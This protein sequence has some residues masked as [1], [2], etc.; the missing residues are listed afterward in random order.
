M[1]D[2]NIHALGA[3]ARAGKWPFA[4]RL[5]SLPAGWAARA[6]WAFLG[7][8]LVLALSLRLFAIGDRPFWVDE[9]A[10]LGISRLSLAEFSRL[11][12]PVEANPP[13]YYLLMK[14]WYDLGG[15][16]EAWMRLPSALAGTATLVPFYFFCRR[17]FGLPAA[18][19]GIVLLA[20]T[21]QHVRFS[22]EARNYALFCLV[23]VCGLLVMQSLV[24]DPAPAGLR[25]WLLGGAL[26]ALSACL[27][28]LHATGVIAA[29]AI[30][31]Y[32]AVTL[33]ASGRASVRRFALLAATG[34]AGL[35]L[36][37]PW[38]VIAA[39]VAFSPASV[40]QW[41]PPL[42]FEVALWRVHQ[43]LF[44]WNLHS[45]FWPAVLATLGGL[46]GAVAARR[47][48]PQLWGLLAALGFSAACFPL[49]SAVV[50]PIVFERTLLFVALLMTILLASFV[51]APR[52]SVALRCVV[53]AVLLVSQARA[54]EL[55]YRRNHY[56]ELWDDAI[57]RLVR[58][59]KNDA[60]LAL[61]V[62]DSVVIEDTLRREGHDRGVAVLAL[63][64]EG[65]Y[66]PLVRA[67]VAPTAAWLEV[68]PSFACSPVAAAP[69][70]WIIGR[71]VPFNEAEE[72]R[73][74]PAVLERD[75]A[76]RRESLTIGKLR[77]EHWTSPGCHEG[78][79]GQGDAAPDAGAD[80]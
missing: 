37:T 3:A 48:E 68:P 35:I 13:G 34:V 76:T 78:A 23:F 1:P 22:Q 26:A 25:R 18:L 69:G 4:D 51:G 65:P 6:E 11:V 71:E 20:V 64:H 43:A 9:A 55:H 74:L 57:Q 45:L 50:E 75:G 63:P 66:V 33:L 73:G 56:G 70:V 19:F 14:F 27:L 7:A 49:I 60:V 12:F 54:V 36:A 80:E 53:A 30:Y 39:S 61:G 17:A 46:A 44:A 38:L 10:T 15:G 24:R 21:A 42:T 52:A 28:Y 8:T 72:E 59:A 40:M 58:D 29:G 2:T 62:F 41:Q 79:P 77:L 31:V 47:R 5:A 32:G 67:M 16:S